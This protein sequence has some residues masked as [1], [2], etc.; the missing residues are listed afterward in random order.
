MSARTVVT[1]H[2]P[3]EVHEPG[4]Y[5]DMATGAHYTLSGFFGFAVARKGT[6]VESFTGWPS[7]WEDLVPAEA[8]SS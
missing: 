4:E 7:N 1:G 5:V 2:G 8:V 3:V 6:Y